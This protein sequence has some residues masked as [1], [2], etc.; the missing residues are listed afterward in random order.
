MIARL[1]ILSCAVLAA[2]A[3]EPD[4]YRLVTYANPAGFKLEISGLAALPDG[5]M[6]AAI[7]KGE[8]WIIDGLNSD[9]PHGLRYKRFASGLHEPLGLAWRDGALYTAQRTE[10]TR[11]KDTNGD[12]IADEYTTIAKGWGVTGNYHEYAYG[13]VFDPWG[14]AWVTLNCGIGKGVKPQDDAWRGW[15]LQIKPDGS[16]IPFSGGFRSPCGLGV[17]AA[18]D[19]FASDQQGNWFPTCALIHLQPGVFHG[20]KDALKHGKL[21]AAEL[22]WQQGLEMTIMEA[23]KKIP[24]YRLPAVWFPYGKMGMSATD[25][26]GDNTGGRFG[27]FEDQLFVGEFTMSSVHRVFLEKIDGQYQGACFRFRDKLQ[28]A[29][30]RL[31][32]NAKGAL[33]IGQSNRGWNSLGGRSYGLQK[34]TWTGR[35]PF[36]IEEMRARPDGFA[37]RFTR[38]VDPVSAADPLAYEIWRYTYYY[39]ESYG[40]KE[41]DR[42]KVVVAGVQLAPDAMEVRLQLGELHEGY[43]YELVAGDVR[44]KSGLPVVHPMACYTLNRIPR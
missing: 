6:A 29:A 28:C 26:L 35:T 11:L 43:V 3:E 10:L 13:P 9:D 24:G 22:D 27:P 8:V 40:S 2:A 21:P 7:R 31:A 17:N 38:P 16:W 30:L 23:T 1:I 44:S 41:I 37:L 5:R 4:C 42:R 18:G 25:I 34:L 32:W 36:E 39:H 19:V 12:E 20:H 33:V 14:N 15:S